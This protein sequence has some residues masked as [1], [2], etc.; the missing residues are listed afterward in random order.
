[1]GFAVAP[2]PGESTMLTSD[3]VFRPHVLAGLVLLGLVAS[4]AVAPALTYLKPVPVPGDEFGRSI[5]IL[6]SDVLISAN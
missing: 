1:M 5:A 3:R 2:S 6:G 4:P